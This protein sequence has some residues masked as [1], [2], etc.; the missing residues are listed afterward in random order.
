MWPIRE[1]SLETV[2]WGHTQFSEGGWR[3]GVEEEGVAPSMPASI[4]LGQGSLVGALGVW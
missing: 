3:N 2:S 1:G 4:G